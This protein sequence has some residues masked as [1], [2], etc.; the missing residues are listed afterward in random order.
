MSLNNETTK[1]S[2]AFEESLFPKLQRQSYANSY[3]QAAIEDNDDPHALEAAFYTII[4]ANPNNL[5]PI[6]CLVQNLESFNANAFKAVLQ[7]MDAEFTPEL[8]SLLAGNRIFLAFRSISQL[9]ELGVA[10]K[11]PPISKTTPTRKSLKT[12]QRID[13]E[14]EILQAFIPQDQQTFVTP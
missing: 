6:Y 4:K 13:P 3:L 12:K 9:L 5:I 7:A 11:I 1:S 8:K 10:F 14:I 2:V